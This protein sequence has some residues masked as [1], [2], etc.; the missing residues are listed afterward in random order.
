VKILN[1]E[2]KERETER[3]RGELTETAKYDQKI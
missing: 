2:E 1:M 3:E